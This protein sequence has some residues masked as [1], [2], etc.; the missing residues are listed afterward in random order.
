[1]RK[2]GALRRPASKADLIKHAAT[3]A[4]E[5]QD[6]EFSR[7]HPNTRVWQG[8]DKAIDHL[9]KSRRILVKGGTYALAR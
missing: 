3:W 6:L 5:A 9:L 8:L 7:L 1:M 4:Q 2:A